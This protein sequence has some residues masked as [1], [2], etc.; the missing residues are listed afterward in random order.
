MSKPPKTIVTD[1]PIVFRIEGYSF[2]EILL[3]FHI[4]IWEL[5]PPFNFDSFPP[6]KRKME[7]GDDWLSHP[8]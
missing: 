4:K 1:H 8:Y 2:K 6:N 3:I 5:P 7:G